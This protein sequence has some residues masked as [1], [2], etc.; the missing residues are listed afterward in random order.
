MY[1]FLGPALMTN[2]KGDIAAVS[3]TSTQTYYS[4][5]SKIVLEDN[6]KELQKKK[7]A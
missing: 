7:T 4:T 5:F 6:A 1:V 2:L 3:V